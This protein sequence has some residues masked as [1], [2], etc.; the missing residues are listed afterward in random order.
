MFSRRPV[1]NQGSID[2]FRATAQNT[3]RSVVGR[4]LKIHW[5]QQAIKLYRYSLPGTGEQPYKWHDV[6]RDEQ[7]P[8]LKENVARQLQAVFRRS[9]Y[10]GAKPA[11]RVATTRRTAKTDPAKKTSPRVT[12]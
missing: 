12:L 11:K 9:T 4:T 2:V 5:P 8:L 10:K 7:Q 1:R 6:A 3:A